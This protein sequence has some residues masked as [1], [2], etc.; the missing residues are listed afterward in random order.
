MVHAVASRTCATQ[1]PFLQH[2]IDALMPGARIAVAAVAA[3]DP[4]MSPPTARRDPHR[5]R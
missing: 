3:Y 5:G 4:R 1:V 2:V